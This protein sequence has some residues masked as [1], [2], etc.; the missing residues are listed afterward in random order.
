MIE[1][2]R[3]VIE[4]FEIWQK[5]NFQ[6]LPIAEHFSHTSPFGVVQGKKAYLNLVESNAEKFLGYTFEIQDAIYEEDK[7]CV[8][9]KAKQGDDFELEVSEW[10]YINMGLIE[11]VVAYYHIGEIREDRELS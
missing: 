7:A 6:D 3:L 4:W 10:H 1:S 5:G 2:E 9:Y 8:R 11:K